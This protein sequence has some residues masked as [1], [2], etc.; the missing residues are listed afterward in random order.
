MHPWLVEQ[1][2]TLVTGYRGIGKTWFAL[3]IAKAISTGTKFG[4]WECHNK[5]R[6]MHIDG[7]LP[8]IDIKERIERLELDLKNP[9]LLFYLDA[10]AEMQDLDRP[11]LANPVWREKMLDFFKSE[12]I[13]VAIY[14][15]I[16]ALT[17]GIEEN[18]AEAWDPIADYLKTCR[19]RGVASILLHHP[20]K[21]GDQRGTSK[22]EDIISNSIVL[23]HPLGYTRDEGA[24][25]LVD[26]TKDR[27]SYRYSHLISSRECRVIEN[28]NEHYRYEWSEPLKETNV[29]VLKLL[30]EGVV[31]KDIAN[32]VG[33]SSSRISQIKGDLFKKKLIKNGKPGTVELTSDGERFLLN[34]DPEINFACLGN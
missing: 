5:A 11:S 15:N 34:H 21:A 19:H 25:F 32:V 12:R 10:V 31:Q 9:N 17:S 33:V 13:D 24:R 28:A 4:P 1:T 29:L 26:F 14:D 7:E 18:K 8:L 23:K 3:G 20:N 6:V 2:I 30:N 16:S 27:V 22:R